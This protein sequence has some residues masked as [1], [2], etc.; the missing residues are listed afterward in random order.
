MVALRN[1]PWL[2]EGVTMLTSGGCVTRMELRR[3]APAVCR[4]ASMKPAAA[5]SQ[6]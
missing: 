5:A 1:R 6:V 3:P 2:K 4:Q